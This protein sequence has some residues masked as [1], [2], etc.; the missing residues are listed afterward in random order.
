MPTSDVPAQSRLSTEAIPSCYQSVCSYQISMA[1]RSHGRLSLVTWPFRGIQTPTN[2]INLKKIWDWR[3]RFG[4]ERRLRCKDRS[5]RRNF[6][7]SQTRRL[8]RL[9]FFLNSFA[10][11]QNDVFVNTVRRKIKISRIGFK[12]M[13]RTWLKMLTVLT[14][15]FNCALVWHLLPNSAHRMT[16]LKWWCVCVFTMMSCSA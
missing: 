1:G 11:I 2:N 4:S 16:I 6:V 5:A 14:D 15:L 9:I 13:I 7:F 8:R 3:Q 10:C 12:K